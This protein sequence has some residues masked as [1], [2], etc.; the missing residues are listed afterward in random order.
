[1]GELT[2]FGISI[3]SKLA[4]SFDEFIKQKGYVNRSEAVRDLIR[5]ALVELRWEGRNENAV[6]TV[7]IVYDHDKREL[8]EKLTGMQ[9]KHYTS[10]ISSMHVHL[11]EHHCLEVLV[12]KGRTKEI[13][14]IADSIIGTKGVIHG[15]LVMTTTG[16]ELA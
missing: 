9:H 3:D 13:Q 14:K 2:R 1:M 5:K 10:V 11:D 6:G 8:S 7:T 16:K 12:I 4:D 15:D